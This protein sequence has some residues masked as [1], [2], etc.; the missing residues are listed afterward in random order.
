MFISFIYLFLAFK[1]V[2]SNYSRVIL[3]ENVFLCF[4]RVKTLIYHQYSKNKYLFYY[5]EKQ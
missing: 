1:N 3:H 4:T 5:T 2:I